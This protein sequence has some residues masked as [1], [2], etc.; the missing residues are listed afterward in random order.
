[1]RITYRARVSIPLPAA[2]TDGR[3]QRDISHLADSSPRLVQDEVHPVFQLGLGHAP[4]RREANAAWKGVDDDTFRVEL[5]L[6][7]FRLVAPE[8]DDPAAA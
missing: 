2:I 5:R 8:G 6:D 1:M 4:V 3:R 7:C